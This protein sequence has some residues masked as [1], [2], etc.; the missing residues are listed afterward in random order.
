MIVVAHPDD[1]TIGLGA[2]LGRF[3][4]ALLVHLTDGAPRDGEDARN[5]GFASVADYAAAR[6]SRT[7]RG[8][9]RRRGGAAPQ[10]RSRHP[11]QGG[12]AGP[13]RFGAA[14]RRPAASGKTRCRVHACL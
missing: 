5:Y 2:Q 3:E 1:E 10:A 11:R 4:D 6:R 9:A 14:N 13:C 7:G 12:R 8:I